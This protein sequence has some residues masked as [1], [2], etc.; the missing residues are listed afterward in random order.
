MI[1]LIMSDMDGTL[2]DENGRL[3]AEFDE[4]ME[5]LKRRHVI[6]APTSGRQYFALLHQF[7]KYRDDMIFLAEN[8]AYAVYHEAE[9]FSDTMTADTVKK[10]LDTAEALEPEGIY[11]V[12]C[13][14]KG[15]YVKSHNQVF[16]DEMGKYYTQYTF[17]KDFSEVDDAL[18]KISLCDA[19]SAD[20]E[21]T[22]YPRMRCFEGSLQT[23]VSANYW[24]DIMNAGIN[25]GVAIQQVQR[26]LGVR[27]E[28]CAAFGDYL[29]DLQ[30][31]RAVHYSF[32]MEN[33][34]PDIRAAAR[35]QAKSNVEH[36]V[37]LAIRD[38][39]AQGLI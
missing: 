25:K 34:H 37:I 27:P 6:F 16:L 28:E 35:F 24:V 38:F 18:I 10:V 32:A 2:L 7:E 22:I 1:K 9:M 20:A 13:G 12:L 39:M 31:M 5:E 21:H 3:P 33:A 29:N 15:A 26:I 14:K 23:A 8:G 4:I 17:V 36:G 19:A 30:M 11:P